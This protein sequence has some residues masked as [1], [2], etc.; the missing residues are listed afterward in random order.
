MIIKVL[1]DMDIMEI[2]KFFEDLCYCVIYNNENVYVRF[3]F[4]VSIIN[5]SSVMKE[6]FFER[7]KMLVL[8]V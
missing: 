7:C 8:V 1:K 4:D 6:Y 5:F 3:V 2:F